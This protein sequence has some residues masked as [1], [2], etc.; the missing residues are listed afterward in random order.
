MAERGS[1]RSS[2]GMPRNS[3]AIGLWIVASLIVLYPLPF[4][5][6][7]EWAAHLLRILLLLT[8]SLWILRSKAEPLVTLNA[9]T[10]FVGIALTGIGAILLTHHIMTVRRAAGAG[11]HWF[12]WSP[13][14]DALAHGLEL[15]VFCA[16]A[17]SLLSADRSRITL[18]TNV[19]IASATFQA[20]YGLMRY[21]GGSTLGAPDLQPTQGA[22]GTF[23]NPDHFSGYL[24]MALPVCLGFVTTW[25]SRLQE[26]SGFKNWFLSLGDAGVLKLVVYLVAALFMGL[27]IVFSR[28]R[29]GVAVLL[30]SLLAVAMF[31]RGRRPESR[32]G[33]SAAALLI[34]VVICALWIGLDPVYEKFAR[35]TT[36]TSFS[37][38]LTYWNTSLAVIRDHPWIGIGPDTLGTLF[39]RYESEDA[40]ERITYAHNAYVQVAVEYGLAG[41]I[42]WAAIAAAV[43]WRLYRDW[44]RR[45]YSYARGLGVGCLAG[46]LA[47]YL[48]SL[49]DYHLS[50]PA[51]QFAFI[52]L[53]VIGY[54]AVKVERHD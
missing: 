28:C 41:F 42:L 27:G 51:T 54:A 35:T 29:S 11:M 36:D 49:T 23:I 22:S 38:R 45:H 7:H 30:F 48:H 46:I 17:S 5:A 12:S 13:S 33:K 47:M 2:T 9:F 34:L 31:S 3:D 53:F 16:A 25:R 20:L 24:E 52:M 1:S 39:S 14:I 19:Y 44:G 50:I 6:M 40:R 21:A 15:C 43:T 10:V 37:S 4:G 8:G 32:P 18:L 26:W